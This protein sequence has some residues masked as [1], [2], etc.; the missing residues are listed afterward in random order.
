VAHSKLTRLRTAALAGLLVL[1]GSAQGAEQDES[2]HSDAGRLNFVGDDFRIG[3][4]YDSETDLT[5]EFFWLLSEKADNAWVAEGWFGDESAGGLKMNY[6]WLSGGIEAGTDEAG[7][8]VYSDG[9][10]YK[11]FLAADRNMFDDSKL[12]IG[13]GSERNNRF[14][15]LYA[16]QSTSGERH[17]GQVVDYQEMLVT[18]TIGNHGFSR[19]DTWETITDFYAHPYDWGAGFRVGHYFENR[20]LRLRGGLDYESGDYDSSQLSAFAM[21][22]KRFEDSPH[23]LSLRAE[24]LRKEGDFEI[25]ENDTRLSAFWTYDFGQTFRPATRYRDVQ[26]E[27]IPDPSELPREQVVEVVSNRVTM[28]S[29]ASFALDRAELNEEARAA[30]SDVIASL[31]DVNVTSTID[32]I[33]HTCWLGSDAYNQGLSERRAKTVYEYLVAN[34]VDQEILRWE[35]RGE[36]EPRFSNE[37]EETRRHNRRVELSFTAEEEIMREVIVGEGQPITE[38]VQEKVP[39]EAAWIRRALRN[40]VAHKRTVDFYRYNRVTE[41]HEEGETVIENTGPAA[42]NDSYTVDQDSADNHFAVLVND[43]DPEGDELTIVTVG[44]PSNGTVV[45]S[46][47]GILY[48]PNAGFYGTD[49]FNYSVEDGFGGTASADVTVVVRR[50]NEPP[51]AE[52]DEYTV[53][54]DSSGNLFSVLDNDSD[55]NG[56]AITI[57]AVSPPGHGTVSINGEQVSYTPNPGYF[58]TDVFSYTIEDELGDQDLAT[59]TVTVQDVND[60]PVATDDMIVT[61]KDAPRVIEVLAN[62]YDPDG[63]PLTIIEIIQPENKMGTVVINGDGTV[64]YTPMP[65]WWGTD[66]FQYT[67]SDGRGGTATAT[68]HLEVTQ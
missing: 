21:L 59:V 38:W 29:T 43:S 50:L 64:T 6:H 14:W 54:E 41:N 11:V 15:S 37:T 1:A 18:G 24:V 12:T 34:G 25:D 48:T 31:K 2:T 19:L 5:G 17:L 56:H 4:G 30:L 42:V 52:D 39:V 45:I 27:R 55:P 8:P 58:G 47:S 36:S 67:I 63:D 26:V 51:V 40:P 20:L 53:M 68:V 49:S 3:I 9:R 60:P 28:D 23:G 16:S 62:D 61:V 33:G 13:A 7:N 35:G 46:A 32:V 44:T 57:I 22:E 10:V 65:I 66:S